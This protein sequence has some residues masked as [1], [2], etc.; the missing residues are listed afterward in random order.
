MSVTKLWGSETGLKNLAD[1]AKG[2]IPVEELVEALWDSGS[3]TQVTA[4]TELSMHGNTRQAAILVRAM[5]RAHPETE[6]TFRASYG[7]VITEFLTHDAMDFVSDP[8][9]YPDD[10]IIE[11]IQ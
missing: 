6:L 1:Y 2:I 10:I 5:I 11:Y 8:S 7:E 3:D 4:I 9:E